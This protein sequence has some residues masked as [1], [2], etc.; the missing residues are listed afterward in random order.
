MTKRI[1]FILLCCLAFANTSTA[2]VSLSN[3]RTLF[4]SFDNP[5]Q[6]AFYTDSSKQFA[7]NFF[8]PTVSFSGSA[9]GAAITTLKGI[10]FSNL[11]DSGNLPIDGKKYTHFASN[12]NVY[13]LSFKWF[14][15]VK[16][17][18]EAGFSWQIRN[19]SWARVSNPSFSI[20]DTFN[21]FSNNNYHDIFNNKGYQQTFH[22]FA[23]TYRE[24]YT[25]TVGLGV[26]L[27]LLSGIAYSGAKITSSDIS[28]NH[29]SNSFTASYIANFRSTI[30]KDSAINR[31]ILPTFKNP[32]LAFTTSANF[33][34]KKGWMLLANV[35][36]LGFI[37]WNKSGTKV[38]R[39]NKSIT[40][41]NANAANSDERLADSI[42]NTLKASKY[43][44]EGFYT[45][46]NGKLEVL[47]SK[48]FGAY[49]PNVL[50]SKNI[51]YPGGQATL[52]NN[53]FLKN[54]VL[55]LTPSYNFLKFMNMGGQYLYKTPN[56]EFFIGSDQLFQTIQFAKGA[57]NSDASAVKGNG[58]SAGFYMGLSAKIGRLMEHPLNANRIPGIEQPK[59]TKNSFFRKLLGKK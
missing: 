56:F 15:R 3:S 40:I 53:F 35:K 14:K 21:R 28:I 24:N 20:F 34:L 12:T 31:A 39:I 58:L 6:K 54:H 18:Q 47:V 41:N 37:H 29:V 27:S 59:D 11:N 7:F 38:Y 43:Q 26:K 2:Q 55:S 23:F 22:Q 17:Q 52:I 32:G 49:H 16:Y 50:L 5:A 33:Q 44:K 4:D 10:V 19:D 42:E 9:S 36:D 25:K 8:F 46:I 57:I 1:L 51:W 13:L 30:V 45:P 48:N